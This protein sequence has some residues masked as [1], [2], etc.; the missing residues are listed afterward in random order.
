MRASLLLLCLH[1]SI[2][3]LGLRARSYAGFWLSR[4]QMAIQF[5]PHIHATIF[6]RF[7]PSPGWH[8]KHTTVKLF[9]MRHAQRVWAV[10]RRSPRVEQTVSVVARATRRRGSKIQRA[11]GG[12]CIQRRAGPTVNARRVTQRH[13]NSA[14]G[15]VSK[16][17]FDKSDRSNREQNGTVSP[18]H[19]G[20]GHLVDQ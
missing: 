1:S 4:V 9:A 8:S 11:T 10:L 19:S 18:V 6:P 16:Q 2:G 15:M 7:T 12:Y 3:H 20:S 14:S 5:A 17:G 13:R